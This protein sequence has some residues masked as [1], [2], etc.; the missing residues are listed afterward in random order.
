MAKGKGNKLVGLK[1]QDRVIAACVVPAGASLTL[2][3]RKRPLTLKP[4]DLEGYVG[5]RAS[6]GGH[7]P[8]GYQTVDSMSV[9]PGKTPA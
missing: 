2:L 8:R 1:D 5:A 6:R 3:S 9:E 4:S 7:L